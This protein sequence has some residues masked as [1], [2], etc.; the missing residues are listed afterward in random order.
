MVAIALSIVENIYR[1]LGI[2]RHGVASP[3]GPLA[4]L[5]DTA[6]INLDR[7]VR[8]ACEW[9][10]T[11]SASVSNITLHGDNYVTHMI[12]VTLNS[13]H[14]YISVREDDYGVG[15]EFIQFACV[16]DSE[17]NPKFFLKGI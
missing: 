17:N 10:R 14:H 9:P 16:G 13:G 5:L 3:N 1:I 8:E 11:Y 2:G 6:S 7:L 12:E 15:S 4:M